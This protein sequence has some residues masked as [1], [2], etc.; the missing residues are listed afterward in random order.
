MI[1]SV[2]ASHAANTFWRTFPAIALKSSLTN[3]LSSPDGCSLWARNR[4]HVLELSA[5]VH[6]VEH[7]LVETGLLI[8]LQCR[9]C[10]VGCAARAMSRYH[11]VAG[12]GVDALPIL[13]L[14]GLGQS[15]LIQAGSGKFQ[16]AC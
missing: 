8:T 14:K 11:V 6:A 12:Q 4:E 2:G 13:V 9:P 1:M 16:I 10:L 5:I 3:M 15:G 7:D